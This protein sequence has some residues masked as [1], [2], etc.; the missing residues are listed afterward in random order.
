M[1]L[2]YGARQRRI[3]AAETDRTGAIA[4]AIA[5]DKEL[6]RTLLRAVGVPVP[7]GRP[8]ADADDAWAAACDIG[9]PV[10]V[11]PRDGNQGRGVATNLTTREQVG[12]GLR[13]RL[14]G[15]HAGDRREVRAGARLSP[16]GRR[17]QGGGRRPPRAGP[18]RWAT[19]AAHRRELVDLANLD[20][21]R[22]EHHATVLSKIKLDAVALAVLADQG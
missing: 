17:R 15:E 18:G 1:Q 20:P 10:V 11:K 6:T 5:Q 13:G 7:E 4:E 19:A 12:Q 21:R 22:G 2:G 16:A 3:Q 14:G 9:V 8:V